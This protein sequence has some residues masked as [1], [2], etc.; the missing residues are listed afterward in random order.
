[1]FFLFLC[2]LLL[3]I[4]YYMKQLFAIFAAFVVTISSMQDR[5]S[6]MT[7][8]GVKE[9]ETIHCPCESQNLRLLYKVLIA[10][11][12]QTQQ[13]PQRLQLQPPPTGSSC[14]FQRWV[15][16]KFLNNIKTK[17][18]CNFW[19]NFQKSISNL[20]PPFYV[21]V[22]FILII[23]ACINKDKYIWCAFSPFTQNYLSL[24]QYWDA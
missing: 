7:M 2:G 13:M 14:V 22:D 17:Q 15:Y 24:G 4:V 18:H 9:I 3:C 12:Q 21:L 20:D 10:R 23:S 19:S 1:M 11:I 5:A 8:S 16:W 6:T